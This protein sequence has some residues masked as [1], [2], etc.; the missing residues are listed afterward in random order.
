M[1]KRGRSDAF[2]ISPFA[3]EERQAHLWLLLRGKAIAPRI[4][5]GELRGSRFPH[6][7]KVES[8]PRSL[9]QI[10]PSDHPRNL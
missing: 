6:A 9:P 3:G 2:G 1:P 7:G 8:V 10:L 4:I 5:G